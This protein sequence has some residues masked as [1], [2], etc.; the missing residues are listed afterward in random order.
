MDRCTLGLSPIYH[1]GFR[2]VLGVFGGYFTLTEGYSNVIDVYYP[3]PALSFDRVRQL[4][5]AVENTIDPI[6]FGR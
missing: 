3:T 1:R 6:V 4:R 5:N 2:E